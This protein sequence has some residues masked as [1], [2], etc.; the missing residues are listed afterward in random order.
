MEFYSR[1][2]SYDISY[3]L[4]LETIGCEDGYL[5]Y[6]S[7]GEL[8]VQKIV[9]LQDQL[10]ILESG[11]KIDPRD[12]DAE[13][14]RKLRAHFGKY[15]LRVEKFN[16]LEKYGLR[17]ESSKG[18]VTFDVTAVDLEKNEITINYNG[19]V[20]VLDAEKFDL[21]SQRAL[22]V[23]D[24]K[25][26]FMELATDGLSAV[27]RLLLNPSDTLTLQ[28]VRADFRKFD[29]DAE[30]M[31]VLMADPQ[32]VHLEEF[33]V[34]LKT[35]L[36]DE[37]LHVTKFVQLASRLLAKKNLFKGLGIY[38]KMVAFIADV[39]PR[40][41]L[42]VAESKIRNLPR[43]FNRMNVENF[44]MSWASSLKKLNA[45]DR[46]K[47]NDF[48]SDWLQ[49]MLNGFQINDLV[50]EKDLSATFAG[51]SYIERVFGTRFKALI[52]GVEGLQNGIT[53]AQQY[54]SM[55]KMLVTQ[56]QLLEGDVGRLVGKSNDDIA[57][58]VAGINV[59]TGRG[60]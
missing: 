48:G 53:G 60:A 24:K 58:I 20:C 46:E 33:M 5:Y 4:L 8:R 50:S 34:G 6:S 57:E 54:L 10:L 25:Q 56:Y 28:A 42:V 44:F 21:T 49:S 38:E 40:L 45:K 17:I 7:G 31:D 30:F 2:N 52:Y 16:Y 41:D 1:P 12:W 39:V 23:A 51:L 18:I 32:F 59:V 36:M 9:G 13:V 26:E 15:H 27:E 3:G 22:Y 47:L 55:R 35:L 43:E 29:F 37:V 14:Q 11:G 19:Y